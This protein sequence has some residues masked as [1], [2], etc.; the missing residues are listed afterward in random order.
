MEAF[1]RRVGGR[2]DV[3][4]ATNIE[5]VDYTRA[6]A[7]LRFTLSGEAVH[8]PSAAAVWISVDGKALQIGAGQRVRL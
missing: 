2:E 3:W 6:V 5:I 4:Y 7:S 1:C 8:N